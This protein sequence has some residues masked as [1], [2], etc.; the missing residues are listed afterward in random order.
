VPA[1]AL[2]PVADKR[3][4]SGND[5]AVRPNGRCSLYALP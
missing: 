3:V 5:A 4:R 2:F 1:L